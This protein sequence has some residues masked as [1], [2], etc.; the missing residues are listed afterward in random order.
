[1]GQD[2]TKPVD[3]LTDEMPSYARHAIK[4]G[5]HAEPMGFVVRSNYGQ[6]GATK[7]PMAGQTQGAL[8]KGVKVTAGDQMT[9]RQDAHKRREHPMRVQRLPGGTFCALGG[10]RE[11]GDRQCG[12]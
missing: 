2:M 5:W 12:S 3:V 9:A 11:Q 10:E 7:R 4:T 8:S 1:M 6:R